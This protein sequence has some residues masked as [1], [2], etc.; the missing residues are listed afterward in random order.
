MIILVDGALVKAREKLLSEWNERG[1]E[2]M[3]KNQVLQI[4]R[5]FREYLET[6]PSIQATCKVLRS[7]GLVQG[8]NEEFEQSYENPGDWIKKT[9]RPSNF[10]RV[11]E[12]LEIEDEALTQDIEALDRMWQESRKP[13]SPLGPPLWK[14]E[15][16]TQ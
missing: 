6:S 9:I 2:L 3:I 7:I 5:E 10:L 11:L 15:V 16:G 12:A 4:L 14:M 8:S 13:F 1:E